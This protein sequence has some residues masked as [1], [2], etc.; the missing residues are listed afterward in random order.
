MCRKKSSSANC[1]LTLLFRLRIAREKESSI[2]AGKQS[3]AIVR[4]SNPISYI[5]QAVAPGNL[6]GEHP[7]KFVLLELDM[8]VW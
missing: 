8:L 2:F 1:P 6:E 4:A 5:R 3:F 7:C